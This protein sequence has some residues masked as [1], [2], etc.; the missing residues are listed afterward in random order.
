MAAGTV[1]LTF[2]QIFDR[3]TVLKD[4]LDATSEQDL[5]NLGYTSG[6]VATLKTS[7]NDLAQLKTI[8][9]GDANLSV[10]K[11]FTAFVRR[12]WGIGV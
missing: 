10:A 6:E 5:I 1:A 3:V 9:L 4:F 7:I 11:D 2:L 8:W 12:L